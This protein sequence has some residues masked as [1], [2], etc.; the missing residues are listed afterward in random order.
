MHTTFIA[1]VILLT[2]QSIF[3]VSENVLL[4][5]GGKQVNAYH[6]I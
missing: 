6:N 1:Y 5:N 4:R 2:S 3:I